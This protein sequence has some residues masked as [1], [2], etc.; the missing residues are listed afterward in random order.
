M[1]QLWCNYISR[2]MINVRAAGERKRR[3]RGDFTG[4]TGLYTPCITQQ[5]RVIRSHVHPIRYT[6]DFKVRRTGTINIY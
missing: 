2:P 6:Y 4:Q 5:A 1:R 3:A